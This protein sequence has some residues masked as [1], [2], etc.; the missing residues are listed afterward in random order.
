MYM[1]K[2]KHF[3]MPLVFH[4]QEYVIPKAYDDDDA[5]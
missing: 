1:V 2:K 4:F 3:K 5:L